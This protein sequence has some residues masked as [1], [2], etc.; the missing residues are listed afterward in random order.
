MADNKL[1]LGKYLALGIA[2]GIAL[3]AALDNTLIGLGIGIAIG[4][5]FFYR[6][7]NSRSTR[8]TILRIA[9]ICVAFAVH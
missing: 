3:G 2:V 5:S 6:R 4:F 9:S 1:N 7:R 8:C